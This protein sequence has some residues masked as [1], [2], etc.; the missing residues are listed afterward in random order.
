MRLAGDVIGEVDERGEPI[1]G[2][3]LLVLLNGHHEKIPFTLPETK[4]E[5]HWEWLLDTAEPAASPP[6]TGGQPYELEG[7]SF[8]VLRICLPPETGPGGAC[9]VSGERGREPPVLQSTI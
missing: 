3:T 4:P 9:H 6:L 1:V 7:R 8:A 5:H 2:D